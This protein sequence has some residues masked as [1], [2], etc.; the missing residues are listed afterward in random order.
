MG[1][2]LTSDAGVLALYALDQR[3]KMTTA[4]A[5]CIRDARDARYIRN[6]IEEMICQRVHQIAA[7]Y[8]DRND[9]NWLRS[10]PVFKTLCLRNPESDLDL[11]LQPTLSRLENAVSSKDLMRISRWLL[12]RYLKRKKRSRPEEILLDLDSSDDPRH[13][14]QEFSFFH[15]Y[16]DH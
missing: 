4:V 9:A 10:D 12:K 1:G 16:F 13:G 5:C 3:E 6:Q 8:E 14:Q 2:N 15:G 7:G 11:A